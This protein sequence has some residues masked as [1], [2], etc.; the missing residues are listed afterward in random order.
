MT[1]LDLLVGGS[2]TSS[3][4]LSFGIL[5]MLLN[6]DVQEKVQQELDREVPFGPIDSTMKSR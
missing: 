5:Y 3:K 1:V 4:T 2:E 6:P